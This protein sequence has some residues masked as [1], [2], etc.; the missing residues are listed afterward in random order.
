MERSFEQRR[1]SRSKVIGRVIAWHI[2]VADTMVYNFK[3]MR[4]HLLPHLHRRLF[5]RDRE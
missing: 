1:C 3:A 4:E 2:F 5:R